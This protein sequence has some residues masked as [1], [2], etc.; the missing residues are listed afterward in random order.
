VVGATYRLQLGPDLDLA[1]AADLVDYLAELGVTHLYLSPVLQ[2]RPGS[3]HGYDVVDP[4]AVSTELGG[5]EALRTLAARAHERGLGLLVDIVPNHLGTDL[6]NPLWSDLLAEGRAGRAG[7]VFDVDWTSPLPGTADKV[8]LPVLGRPYGEVLHH[9]GFHIVREDGTD[10]LAYHEHRFPLSQAS[11]EAL[12]RSGGADAVRGRPGEP[13]TWT[14]LHSLLEQQ[15]Y[16]LVHWRAGTLVNY[17]R[18]FAV[19]DLAGVRVEDEAVFDTVHERILALVADGVID[20]LRVDHVDGLADPRRYLERLAAA[21]GDRWVVVEKILAPGEQLPEWPVAGTTGY[22]FANHVVALF[23][24]PAAR[25]ALNAAA[26]AFHALPP[27]SGE[28][29]AKLQMLTSDLA[30]DLWRLGRILWAVT[31]DHLEVRDVDER[32]CRD[33]LARTMIELEVYRTYVDPVDGTAG[34]H[35]LALLAPA[36]TAA[37]ADPD[38]VA[39]PELYRFLADALTGHAGTSAAHLELIRRF[40]QLSGAVMAKGVE[41]TW[42]YRH[43]RLL[44]VN[45]VGGVTTRLGSDVAAFHDTNLARAARHPLGMLSTATHDT[46]RGEDVRLRIAALSELADRWQAAVRRWGSGVAPHPATAYLVYQTLVGVWPLV[47]A[48]PHLDEL[49]RRVTAYAVKAEREAKERTSWTD[50]D[51]VFESALAAFVSGL[52]DPAAGDVLGELAEIATAAAEIAMVSGLA[53][54]LLRC[55]SPGVPDTYQGMELW[56]D[57]LVDPDN[58]RPVDFTHR[59]AVLAALDAGADPTDLWAQRRDGRV[60]AWVLSRGLRARAGLPSA[61]GSRGAYVPLEVT[62]RWAGHVVAFARTGPDGAAAIT[63]TPRLPGAVMGPGL[64][65]PLGDAWGD[66]RVV[67]PPDL[68]G[69]AWHDA[70]RPAAGPHEPTGALP[71]TTLLAELPVALLTAAS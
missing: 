8:V 69:S 29:A 61:F 31:A 33:A 71:L 23:V 44:A 55:T 24:D 37:A 60:K 64:A 42:L 7:A 2:A 1:A 17:R 21:V 51:E 48:L 18:F 67:L 34:A 32:A 43:R 40:Q 3:P 35:D 22:D 13:A 41:D 39:P 25:P 49:A 10:R 12:E 26:V 6:A 62:G 56:D 59:R 36:V 15:H 52:L 57:H 45:E 58:R 70:L 9:G 53:Q 27:G 19:N 50:P 14:R 47:D 63:V 38:T 54:V 28:R 5:E 68:A 30:P 46:K 65:A 16:R 20:G 4:A 11:L 66:T